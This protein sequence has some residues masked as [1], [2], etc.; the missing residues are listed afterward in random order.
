MYHVGTIYIPPKIHHACMCVRAPW[1]K[2][3]SEEKFPHHLPIED[4]EF[5]IAFIS[6]CKTDQF[7]PQ[8]PS[9]VIQNQD[10]RHAALTL[11][12]WGLPST[13]QCSL[14]S[15]DTTGSTCSISPKTEYRPPS[16]Q[17]QRLVSSSDINRPP[18]QGPVFYGVI[19]WG[20]KKDG[21]DLCPAW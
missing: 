11:F 2:M 5:V 15:W 18:S 7:F 13:P 21:V 17:P 12:P 6:A 10:S 8:T 19:S 1:L 3:I 14:T 9:L 4:P 16:F 20:W